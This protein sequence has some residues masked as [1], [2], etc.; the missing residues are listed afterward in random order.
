MTAPAQVFVTHQS[1]LQALAY[2][3]VGS[4]ADAEDIVQ[5]TF[6]K[7][8]SVEHQTIE[9]ARAYLAKAVTNNCLKH[10]E[11]RSR[12]G[13]RGTADLPEEVTSHES[14]DFAN[15]DLENE[16]SQALAVVHSKLDPVEKAVYLL[17]E[18]FNMEYEEL[19]EVLDKKKENCRQLFSRAKK[20]ME[21]ESQR[22]TVNLNRHAALLESF[23]KACH[24]DSP[25]EFVRELSQD[26]AAKFSK[27]EK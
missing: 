4:L 19:Q 3:M 11:Q 2:K 27:Q 25:Y 18:V 5:D 26:I 20:N 16:L 10:L 6:L 23:K 14:G 8:L 24:L 7:W 13:L 22:F 1:F 15:F 21:Q 9:N 17:R 12:Q